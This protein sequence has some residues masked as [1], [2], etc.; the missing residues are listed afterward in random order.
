MAHPTVHVRMYQRLLGDCFL[1]TIGAEDADAPVHVLIDCGIL[2]G[3]EGGGAVMEEVTDD[4]IATTKGKLDLVVVTHEH[5]DHISGFRRLL[6]DRRLRIERLWL[7]WTEDDQDGQANALRTDLA[8]RRRAVRE[9]AKAAR[10]GAREASGDATMENPFALTPGGAT[11]GLEAFLDDE[12]SEGSSGGSLGVAGRKPR[13]PLLATLKK[14]VGRASTDFLEPGD[15]VPLPGSSGIVAHVLGPPRDEG[16]LFKDL[17]S[18]GSDKETYL[19]A[20]RVLNAEWMVRLAAGAPDGGRTP[21]MEEA[22]PFSPQ[23]RRLTRRGIEDGSLGGEDAEWVRSHYFSSCDPRPFRYLPAHLAARTDVACDTGWRQEFRRIDGVWLS[24]VGPLALKLDSDTNNTSLV[25]AL[26]MPDGCVLL[27]AADAQVGNWESWHRQRYGRGRAT[28]ADLLERTILYKVGHHGSHNATLTEKGLALMTHKR[29]VA[30]IP[31]VETVA[32]ERGSKGWKMPYAPLLAELLKRTEG[33]L[34]RGDAK[35]GCD[36][37]GASLTRDAEFRARVR[38]EKSARAGA[39][40]PQLYV[41]Y[42]AWPI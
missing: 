36:V 41:E 39:D 11:R 19:T 25:L 1:L 35:P 2:N 31:T 32:L 42:R 9:A 30:M 28:A 14:F 37:G 10:E 38:V 26:E 34:L 18:A 8:A 33:R 29:L 40:G 24:A 17:P 21:R 15:T 5:A 13:P 22:S 7:A 20:T 16:L 27:F 23:H 6:K 4:I 3:V 12:E